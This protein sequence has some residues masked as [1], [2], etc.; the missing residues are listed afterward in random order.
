MR[1][2]FLKL[3]GG[4]FLLFLVVVWQACKKSN[5]LAE[6]VKKIEGTWKLDRVVRNDE[7]ITSRVDI[8]DFELTFEKAAAATGE[9]GNY[10]IANGAPFAVSKDG[11]WSL[12]DP[13]YPFYILLTPVQTAEP[14]KVKFNFPSIHGQNEIKLTFSPGCASNTYQYFLKKLPG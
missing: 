4:L 5:R 7:D 1:S 9:S 6:P 3:S 11:V 14:V 8:S 12:D 13:A 10:T 2:V